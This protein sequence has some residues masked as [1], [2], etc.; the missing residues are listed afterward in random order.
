MYDVPVPQVRE[1]G[2]ERRERGAA[3]AVAEVEEQSDQRV[4][5]AC[6]GREE[7]ERELEKAKAEIYALQVCGAVMWYG[8]TCGAGRDGSR[9]GGGGAAAVIRRGIPRV[10]SQLFA[11]CRS[12]DDACR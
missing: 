6:R 8:D 12:S 9:A 10:G 1:L 11:D 7:A 3:A 5:E 2:L 4:R